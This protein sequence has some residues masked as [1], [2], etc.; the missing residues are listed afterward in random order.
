[1]A[2][3]AIVRDSIAEMVTQRIRDNII[4]RTLKSG[5]KIS[6][7]V[8][9][10]QMNVSRTPVREAFRILQSEG[11]LEYR[12]RRGVVVTSLDINDVVKLNEVRSVLEMF[13][14][15]SAAN[16]I[17]ESDA[18]ELRQIN[19]NFLE[20]VYE[21]SEKAGHYD[22]ELHKK[23]LDITKNMILDE[24]LAMLYRRMRMIYNFVPIQKDRI[25]CSWK[26]HDDIIGALEAKDGESAKVYM[27]IHFQRST[28]SLREKI[29]EYNREIQD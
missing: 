11:L 4:N 28:A 2:E 23:I 3:K 29:I 15:Y 16:H 5:D 19:R 18:A 13:S 21:N 7:V 20:C 8:L 6:E 27:D 12:P 24:Q 1:M 25:L 26:E 17:T 14:A 22:I 10:R 9:S